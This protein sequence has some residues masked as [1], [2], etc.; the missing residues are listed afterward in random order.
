M[1]KPLTSEHFHELTT[2]LKTVN[3]PIED[4][5]LGHQYFIGAFDHQHL[6]GTAALEVY[7]QK[8]LLRSVAVLPKYQKQGIGEQLVIEM[9]N[10]A[11]SN[12]ITHLFLITETAQSFFNKNGYKFIERDKLPKAIKKCAQF[13]HL[14][15]VSAACMYIKLTIK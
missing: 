4:I 6:I 9:E 10:W 1:I 13:R 3:L 15:P 7:H 12:S 14:C 8:A 5:D 11:I 2:L